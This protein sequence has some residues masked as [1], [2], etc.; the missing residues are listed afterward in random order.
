M[1][2]ALVCAGVHSVSPAALLDPKRLQ[3]QLQ[4][5]QQLQ[6]QLQQQ[7]ELQ[8][9]LQLQLQQLQFE[10]LQL[11]LQQLEFLLLRLIAFSNSLLPFLPPPVRANIDPGGVR[12]VG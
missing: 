4:L 8:F 1:R 5:E 12:G 2:S 7:L 9:E 6:L 11:E 3:R 10:Q